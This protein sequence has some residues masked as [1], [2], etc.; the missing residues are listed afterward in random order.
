VEVVSEAEGERMVHSSSLSR[1]DG[2]RIVGL[3]LGTISM[4]RLCCEGKVSQWKVL[5]WFG[6]PRASTTVLS[7]RR[8]DA[9]TGAMVNT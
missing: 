1:G 6:S 2:D 8:G 4:Y 3:G 7:R 9:P 5:A